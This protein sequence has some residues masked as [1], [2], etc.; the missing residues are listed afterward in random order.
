[1]HLISTLASGI[2]GAEDGTAKVYKRGTST[3][4]TIYSDFVGTV[5]AQPS[6]GYVLDA[7]G[8]ATLYVNELV[9]VF[10]FDSSGT[11]RREFVAGVNAGGVEVRSASF[12]GT[13]YTSGASGAGAPTTLQAVL[14][15]WETKNGSNDWRVLFG[16]SAVTIQAAL[17]SIYGIFINVKDPTYGAKGDGTTD[18]TTAVQAAI[19]AAATP[20]SIVFFPAGTYRTTSK[21]TVPADVSLWGTGSGGSKIAMDHA[22][23]DTLE[24]GAGTSSGYQ[25]IRGLGISASQTNTGKPISMTAAGTRKLSV[26]NSDLNSTFLYTGDIVTIAGSSQAIAL[27]S[28]TINVAGTA[29]NGIT[30][31]DNNSVTL[32]QSSIACGTAL[33]TGSLVYSAIIAVSNSSFSITGT[34]VGAGTSYMVRILNGTFQFVNVSGSFFFAN[35]SGPIAI[36]AVDSNFSTALIS[37]SGNTFYNFTS[38]YSGLGSGSNR[39]YIYLGAREARVK[40][41]S[42]ANTAT[43][44]VP[45]LDYGVYAL[46]RTAAGAQTLNADA[47]GPEGSFLTIVIYQATGGALG[48][49][50]LG[51]NFAAGIATFNPASGKIN[52]YTFRSVVIGGGGAWLPVAP[53]YAIP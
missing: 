36:S 4:A 13:D 26:V 18:D 24:Y 2:S 6:T 42:D 44:T 20:K 11:Q 16:G 21:L 49:V 53:L 51:T 38:T 10:V 50:T 25:E 52:T 7:Y 5:A 17:A 23:A 34:A 8:G 19:T 31:A 33:Y 37:E 45:A 41:V 30:A 48:N 29:A 27:D 39:P 43:L 35:N 32:H 14:D 12:I 15:L 40:D 47:V 3:L 28:S 9:D 22:T 46:T 1:M